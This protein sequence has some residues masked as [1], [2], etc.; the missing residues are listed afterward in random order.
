MKNPIHLSALIAYAFTSSEHA[1][2]MSDDVLNEIE[3]AVAAILSADVGPDGIAELCAGIGESI[4]VT[5]NP[6]SAVVFA[7]T[8]WGAFVAAF[9]A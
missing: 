4:A 5:C 6:A 1:C 2:P 3:S 7:R 9:L 8:D